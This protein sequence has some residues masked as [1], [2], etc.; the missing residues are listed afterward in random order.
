MNHDMAA[1]AKCL[2]ELALVLPDKH[3]STAECVLEL[4]E[5]LETKYRAGSATLAE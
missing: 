4:V 2:R 3:A 1:I 5:V